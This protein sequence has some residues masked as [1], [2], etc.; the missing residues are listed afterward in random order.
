MKKKV[1]CPYCQSVNEPLEN[2]SIIYCKVCSK[3]FNVEQG[4]RLYSMLLLR[5]MNNGNNELYGSTNYQKAIDNFTNVLKLDE[6]FLDA[7]LGLIKATLYSSTISKSKMDDFLELLKH[8]DADLDFTKKDDFVRLSE[9]YK[10]ILFA[11][12]RYEQV[13]FERLFDSANHYYEKE[14]LEIYRAFLSKY[15][16]TVEGFLTKFASNQELY[17]ALG[18]DEEALKQQLKIVKTKYNEKYPPF[19]GDKPYSLKSTDK[20][21]SINQVI[22]KDN[23]HLYKSRN[24]SLVMMLIFI[25]ILIVG[26]ILIFTI[27]QKLLIGVPIMGVGLLGTVIA[28]ITNIVLKRKL[29]K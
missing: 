17:K 12:N 22:F 2:D 1:I 20:K 3:A 7:I 6:H 28:Y 16:V 11:L 4:A 13:L 24:I 29:F 14:G 27:P 23:R 9:F 10:E 19:V 21:T 18:T 26:V 15:I 25:L 5:Y 8:Y